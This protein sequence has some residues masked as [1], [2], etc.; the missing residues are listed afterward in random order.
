[1]RRLA[2]ISFVALLAAG[3]I[4]VDWSPLLHN[5]ALIRD[6][7]ASHRVWLPA[8]FIV[9]QIVAEVLLLPGAPF[10]VAG[11]LLFGIWWGTL[12]SIF[13]SVFSSMTIFLIV[14]YLGEEGAMHWLHERF[15]LIRRYNLAL[16]ENG[17]RHVLILRLLPFTPGNLLSVSYGL[18][19]VSVSDYFLGTFIGNLPSTVL[20]SYLGNLALRQD[21]SYII[22]GSAVVILISFILYRYGGGVRLLEKKNLS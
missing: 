16:K 20:L 17:F 4:L 21:L 7:I 14:R 3:W 9:F 12:F 13:C 8:I 2:L 19:K 22:S 18:S 10:T 15:T 11:G 5:P 6:S 1:M